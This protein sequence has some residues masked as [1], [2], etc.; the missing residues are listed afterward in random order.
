M[1]K[2]AVF[3][4][5][6]GTINEDEGYIS[7]PEDL[8]LLP[9]AAGA[10][11]RLNR[12]GIKVIVITNQ[13]GVGRGYYTPQDVRAVNRRLDE[14]LALDGARLDGV[15]YC[16]HNPDDKCGCR[17]PET[18]LIVRAAEEHSVDLESS[19]VVGDKASDMGLARGVNAKA[20]LVLTGVG[21]E[22]RDKLDEPA[23]HVAE[24]LPGAVGWILERMKAP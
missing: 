4:D 16:P 13:S 12:E 1:R 7:N 20:V 2:G 9:G 5:R 23:D 8:V 3:L 14:L 24:D 18:G 6:D 21:L 17:K 10:I 15:Y 11:G 19:F 22:E